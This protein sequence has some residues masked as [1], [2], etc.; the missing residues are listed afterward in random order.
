MRKLEIAVFKNA[1][2]ECN[3][4]KIATVEDAIGED[5]LPVGAQEDA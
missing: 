5:H 2:F 1:I 3:P 4:L